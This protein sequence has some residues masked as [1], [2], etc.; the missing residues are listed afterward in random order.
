MLVKEKD[1]SLI[2]PDEQDPYQPYR[3]PK[4]RELRC[5]LSVIRHG[6]RTPKQKVKVKIAH[7]AILSFFDGNDP[8]RQVK[9]KSTKD[10]EHFFCALNTITSEQEEH[11]TLPGSTLLKLQE[12]RAVLSERGGQFRGINRKVQLKP[13]KWT[14]G[15]SADGGA[16]G[17]QQNKNEKNKKTVAEV[18]LIFKYGGVLTQVGKTQADLLG[19]SFRQRLYDLDKNGM[20]SLH[21]TCDNDLKFYASDEGRVQMTAACF[22]RAFLDLEEEEIIP[23]LF[24]LVWNDKRSNML[25]EHSSSDSS[26]ML[27]VKKQLGAIFHEDIDYADESADPQRKIG[28]ISLATLRK[29]DVAVLGNP[30]KQMKMIRDM[31]YDI[32][33]QIEQLFEGNKHGEVHACEQA[34]EK[35]KV[36]RKP[37]EVPEPLK[38][39]LSVWSQLSRTIYDKETDTFDI[40]K[41]PDIFDCAKFDSIHHRK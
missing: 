30:L 5:L 41:L 34:E 28:G 12:A 21:S 7:P 23:I 4:E 18:L 2:E 39:S 3:Q 17:E 16:G 25:L 36:K 8:E 33:A 32:V 1:R 40:S 6:D 38:K 9:L 19:K 37:T 27:R 13:L 35:N 20:L 22:A 26:A 15:T 11:P 14:Q 29:C 31:L 24:A 10:M